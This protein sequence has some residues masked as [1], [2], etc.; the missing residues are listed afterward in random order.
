[1]SRHRNF[2]YTIN[3]YTDEIIEQVKKIDCKYNSFSMEVAPTTGTPHLQGFICFQN[4]K[5]LSAVIKILPHS[6]VE[7]MR[8][9]IDD[10][11]AYIT[12]AAQ[13]WSQGERPLSQAEKGRAGEGY[14]DDIQDKCKRGRFE[15]LPASFTVGNAKV[16]DYVISKFKASRVL[17]PLTFDDVNL[18]L[19]GETGTGKTTRAY[20]L[21]GGQENLYEKGPNKWWCFYADQE[22]VLIDDLD[23]THAYLLRDLKIWCH[24]HPFRAESKGQGAI[25]IRPRVI[26]V[27]SNYMIEE[28]WPN[29]RDSEPILRRFKQIKI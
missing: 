18:W 17:K 2:V 11:V 19:H 29:R 7:V 16:A 10:N 24:H 9:S 20:E 14:W 21:A 22:Y 4:P 26:I 25:K 12:K 8:G 13:A 3:N 1:M 23:L 5:S 15:E 6:H 28:I 27:T